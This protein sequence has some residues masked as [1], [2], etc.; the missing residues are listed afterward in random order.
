MDAFAKSW[1]CDRPALPLAKL[2]ARLIALRAIRTRG[3][4]RDALCALPY[5]HDAD[6]AGADGPGGQ[7]PVCRLYLQHFDSLDHWWPRPDSNRHSV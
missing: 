6:T 3:E 1:R 2:L 4:A 7:A 5:G